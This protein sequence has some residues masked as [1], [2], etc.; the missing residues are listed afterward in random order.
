[1]KIRKLELKDGRGML[2]WMHDKEVVKDLCVNFADK[3]IEDCRD[4]ILENRDNKFNIHMAIADD[5]DNYVGTVSLKHVTVG[6]L[7]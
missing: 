6:S 4:F 3:T 2:S 5:L 1:M 7:Q